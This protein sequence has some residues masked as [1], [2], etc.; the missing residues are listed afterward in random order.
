MSP[1]V[2]GKEKISG[3]ERSLN[4]K[5]YHK[6]YQELKRTYPLTKNFPSYSDF[7]R[8]TLPFED[9]RGNLVFPK[10]LSLK[11]SYGEKAWNKTTDKL[12]EK[13]RQDFQIV[14][15]PSRHGHDGD[16][17]FS[18]KLR[19]SLSKFPLGNH[20]VAT[21]KRG[22]QYYQ[23]PHEGE[24]TVENM[25]NVQ[26]VYIITSPLDEQDYDEIRFI[27]NQYRN[28]GAIEVNLISPFL[29][30]ERED[31][32]IAKR[33]NPNKPPV[34]NGRI[35]K[36][37]SEMRSLGPVINRIATFEPHSSATH[38]F[39]ALSGIALAPLSMEEELIGQIKEKIIKEGA[40]KWVV[41]RPDEGRNIVATR[42]EERF[43]LDGIHL[44]QIR[45]SSDLDKTAE[46]LHLDEQRR[47][48]G[49]NVI[50]YDDEGGTLKTI[51]NVVIEH[52]LPSDVRSVNIFLAHARLQEGKP[53]DNNGWENNLKVMMEKAQKHDPPIKLKIYMTDSRVPVGKLQKFMSEYPDIVEIISVVD[54][55]R[56][57]IEAM[58]AGVNFWKDKNGTDWEAA[59]LQAAKKRNGKKEDED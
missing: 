9:E 46:S 23:D 32:N 44:S 59:V 7:D 26:S 16:E 33:K 2:S 15:V 51:T 25:A 40:G 1:I 14:V 48:R 3:K 49:T 27:A 55:T 5:D 29:A 30:Y 35:I 52:L 53:E 39:A 10:A 42:I 58:V 22:M 43:G 47:L 12:T 8:Q 34:Y 11:R 56:K 20:H 37:Q 19:A 21:F 17:D 36:I 13:Q 57:V 45:D 18:T 54:K 41:V 28:N 50:V 6:G 31:K 24:R 4:E 38:A